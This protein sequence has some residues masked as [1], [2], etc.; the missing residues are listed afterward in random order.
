MKCD[1]FLHLMGVQA[2]ETRI[3]LYV[4]NLFMNINP[5]PTVTPTR[6]GNPP[7]PV[8]P[9]QPSNT[10]PTQTPPNVTNLDPTATGCTPHTPGAS[11]TGYPTRHLNPP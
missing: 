9:T 8:T 11:A 10:H 4:Q 7:D 3:G 1:Y 6:P 5:H 2:P